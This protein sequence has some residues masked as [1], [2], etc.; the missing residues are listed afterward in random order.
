LTATVAKI[1]KEILPKNIKVAKETQVLITGAAM[2]DQAVD[3]RCL[4]LTPLFSF[5]PLEF[6]QMLSS[7]SNDNCTKA[8]SRSNTRV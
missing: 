3:P 1:I 2:G 8:V 4:A 5:A 7:Q 6:L